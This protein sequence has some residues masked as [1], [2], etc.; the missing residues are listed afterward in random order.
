VVIR[1]IAVES[2]QVLAVVRREILC[3]GVEI[4]MLCELDAARFTRVVDTC[5]ATRFGAIP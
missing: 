5:C 1:H 4:G 2:L 3:D